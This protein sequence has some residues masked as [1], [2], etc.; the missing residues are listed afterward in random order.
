MTTRFLV[1]V[2]AAA[3]FG[4]TGCSRD[5]TPRDKLDPI[6]EGKKADSEPKMVEKVRNEVG[7]NL[8]LVIDVSGSM[9]EED[10]TG[11][12]RLKRIQNAVKSVLTKLNPSDTVA[13]VGYAHNTMV[14]LSSTAV[15]NKAIIEKAISSVDSGD[16]DPGGRSMDKALELAID[17]VERRNVDGRLTQLIVVTNNGK[18]TGEANCRTLAA[19]LAKKEIGLT[20]M[21]IGTKWNPVFVKDIATLSEGRWYSLDAT[22][23]KAADVAFNQEFNRLR[24]SR[25]VPKD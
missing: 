6:V 1:L 14:V 19:Q 25:A 9:Y 7:L 4:V 12:S 5:A 18:A 16:I 21:G 2:F 3:I 8:V 20:L 23:A 10:G 22:D 24:H 15:A 17:E 11:I 13:I